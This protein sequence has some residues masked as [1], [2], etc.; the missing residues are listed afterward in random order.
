MSTHHHDV[1][2]AHR[3]R[4]WAL[5]SIPPLARAFILAL[6]ALAVCLLVLGLARTHLDAVATIRAGL[7]VVLSTVFSEATNRVE[8][9]RRYL[10]LGGRDRVWSNPTSV[11]TFAAALLVPLGYAA[12]VVAV[13]YAHL[14]MRSR[15]HRLAYPYKIIFGA[16]LA[17]LGSAAAA[18]VQDIIGIRFVDTG[19]ARAGVTLLALAGYSLVGLAAATTAV[20]LTRHPTTVRAVLPPL[21][22]VGFE[23][24]TLL[25]GVVT[26][27]L[28]VAGP[29]LLPVVPVLVAILHRST[30]VAELQAVANTDPKTGLLNYRAWRELARQQLLA[31]RRSGSPA[32]VLMI[33]LDHFKSIND[34]FGHLAGDRTLNAV[35]DCI[36]EELRGY[37]AVGRFGG[38]EFTALL[39]GADRKTA[40]RI[41]SRLTHAIRA[42]SQTGPDPAPTVT[43]SIGVSNYPAD[44]VELDALTSAA[45]AAMYDAKSTGRDRVRHANEA[46][47]A[48]Q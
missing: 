9:L 30:Q 46:T 19:A 37:D 1:P 6:E 34:E 14:L 22:A 32:A 29:W 27:S 38:E 17:F 47:P 41:A 3:A 48:G 39:G 5:C 35:A 13:I 36:R 23:V 45:D 42:L 20:Y 24:A 28:L 18:G 2:A 40:L 25:L 31:A 10:H 7:L 44:G 21:E 16:T 8:L 43:A 11:W 15:R 26:A 33:D 12:V 4:R